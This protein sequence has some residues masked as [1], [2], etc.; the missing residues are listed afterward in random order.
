MLSFRQVNLQFCVD[1]RKVFLKWNDRGWLPEQGRRLL[2]IF[3][4]FCL[5][6]P[7]LGSYLKISSMLHQGS[8]ID[9]LALETRSFLCMLDWPWSGNLHVSPVLGLQ[10]CHHDCLPG[11]VN[12]KNKYNLFAFICLFSPWNVPNRLIFRGFQL[13]CTSFIDCESDWEVSS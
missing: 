11:W 8:T 6:N 10:V 1:D 12:V 9:P 13:H 5:P 7:I 4:F 3:N 2:M